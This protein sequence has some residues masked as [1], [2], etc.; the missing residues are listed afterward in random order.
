MGSQTWSLDG[1]TWLT[2]ETV[3]EWP[4]NVEVKNGNQLVEIETVNR[5]P[6]GRLAHMSNGNLVGTYEGDPQA[7]GV[8]KAF[9]ENWDSEGRMRRVATV[10]LFR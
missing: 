10:Q 9:D 5:I 6:I 8:V 3:T 7:I 4:S 1:E 2:P